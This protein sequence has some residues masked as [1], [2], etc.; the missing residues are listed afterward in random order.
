MIK[1]KTKSN[2][3]TACKSY[4]HKCN[5][6]KKNKDNQDHFEPIQDDYIGGRYPS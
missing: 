6:C 3:I 2:T 5:R 4:P 1:M